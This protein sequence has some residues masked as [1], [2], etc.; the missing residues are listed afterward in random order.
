MSVRKPLISYMPGR[1]DVWDYL[2]LDVLLGLQE[3]VVD[4]CYDCGKPFCVGEH[5]N[6]YQY[7]REEEIMGSICESC[8]EERR[9][10][11]T[12]KEKAIENRAGEGTKR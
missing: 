4:R 3:R 7:I 12:R 1:T 2:E 10:Y 9:R 5:K 6:V 8:Y 11:E